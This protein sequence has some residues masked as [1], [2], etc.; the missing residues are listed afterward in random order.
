MEEVLIITDNSLISKPNN[1]GIPIPVRFRGFELKIL[2]I[3]LVGVQFKLLLDD[4][5]S[6]FVIVDEKGRSHYVHNSPTNISEKEQL[7]FCSLFNF[8]T[9]FDLEHDYEDY[10][11]K[12]NLILFPKELKGKPLYWG[13]NS[14]VGRRIHGFLE[15]FR[16]GIFSRDVKTALEINYG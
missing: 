2:E 15:F 5:I 16:L 14:L 11:Q 1:E 8:E 10:I 3:V 6:Y 4:E 13:S 12:K 7:G 9:N